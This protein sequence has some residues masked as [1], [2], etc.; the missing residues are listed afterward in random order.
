MNDAPKQ[1]E[2]TKRTWS[3]PS[4]V[5]LPIG[6]TAGGVIKGGTEDEASHIS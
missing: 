2:A 4:I 6:M 5:E 1:P 3:T